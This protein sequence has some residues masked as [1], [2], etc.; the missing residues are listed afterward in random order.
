MA[1]WANDSVMDAALAYIDDSTLLTVCS[2]QPTTYAEAS[3]TYKLAD[4]VMTAGAGNGDYTLANGDT[5]GRKLTVAQQANMDIDSN[6]T[7]TH[8][9]LSISG[10]S[11]LVYVTTCTSQVLTAGGTVTVPAWDI[12]IADPA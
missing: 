3:S 8:V 2:A 11:T 4:V 1:K 10:S 7:A 6:G 12:E 9:A 5:N